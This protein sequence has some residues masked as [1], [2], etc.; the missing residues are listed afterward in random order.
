MV[1]IYQTTSDNL[2]L[3]SRSNFFCKVFFLMQEYL[4]N[5]W[6]HNMSGEGAGLNS[7]QALF[8]FSFQISSVFL[9]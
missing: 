2:F 9:F 3:L 8:Q 5:F 7:D 1:M 6:S 4:F